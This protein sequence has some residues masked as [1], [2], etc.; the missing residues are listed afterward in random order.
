MEEFLVLLLQFL[1]EFILNVLVYFPFDLPS[2]NR[3]RPEPESIVILCSLWL[4][5]GG[6]LAVV[7]LIIFKHTLIKVSAFRIANL[8]LA[9]VVSGLIS[10][11]IAARRAESNRFIVP[12]NH[13]WYAFWFTLGL[14]LIR[15]TYAARA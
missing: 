6:V 1:V 9:P 5:G 13:F 12:R 14:V 15:F 4:V 8:F 3:N 11:A 7:S 10:R 2:K